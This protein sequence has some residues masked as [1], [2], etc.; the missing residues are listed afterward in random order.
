MTEVTQPTNDSIY[1]QATMYHCGGRF[2]I[3]P[4]D[5]TQYN[6]RQTP[7][8]GPWYPGWRALTFDHLANSVSSVGHALSQETLATQRAGQAWCR[9]LFPD[10]Y[11]ASQP[12]SQPGG[13]QGDL[14]LILALGAFSAPSGK[15]R[16]AIATSF[17]VGHWRPHSLSQ[18]LNLVREWLP[19]NLTSHC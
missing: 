14:A 19:T 9:Q 8:G 13:L 17:K 7:P 12:T 11:L 5:A 6:V 10:G 4:Y 1:R 3:V 18:D 2:W 15:S 16:D